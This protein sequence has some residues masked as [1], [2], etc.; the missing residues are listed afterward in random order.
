MIFFMYDSYLISILIA[1]PYFSNIYYNIDFMG[2]YFLLYNM[3]T[4][5]NI[6]I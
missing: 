2:E 1:F 3:Q 6:I 4:I 5:F